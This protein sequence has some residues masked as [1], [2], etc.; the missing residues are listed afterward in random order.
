MHLNPQRLPLLINLGFLAAQARTATHLDKKFP[1]T[2]KEDDFS[3]PERWDSVHNALMDL[4]AMDVENGF[5]P[6]SSPIL[7]ESG[8]W[9]EY[10]NLRSYFD[11]E[12][13]DEPWC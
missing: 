1:F 2:V 9:K 12:E 6:T 3:T 8:L 10:W 5:Y 7:S 13:P 11:T 4:A